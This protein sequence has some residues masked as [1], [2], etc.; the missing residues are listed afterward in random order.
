MY[1]I[2]FHARLFRVCNRCKLTKC[3]IVYILHINQ[4]NLRFVQNIV[5]NLPGSLNGFASQ[6]EKKFEFGFNNQEKTT[7]LFS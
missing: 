6:S 5:F 4:K 1:A 2:L 3:K 7:V